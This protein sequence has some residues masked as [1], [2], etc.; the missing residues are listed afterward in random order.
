MIS[1]TDGGPQ[2]EEIHPRLLVPTHITSNLDTDTLP[3]GGRQFVTLWQHRISVGRPNRN[4]VSLAV[5]RV[6]V[7]HGGLNHWC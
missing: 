1:K 7:G 5:H 6:S 4:V 2:M 3:F